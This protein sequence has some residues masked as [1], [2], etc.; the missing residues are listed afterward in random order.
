MTAEAQAAEAQAAV[1]AGAGAIHVHVRGP[2][3]RESLAALDVAHTLRVIRAA[4]PG[5]PVGIS[6]A[7]WIV[8][9]AAERLALVEAWQTL[10]DFVSVNFDEQGAAALAE[11]LLARGVGV[12]AGLA[13][14]QAAAVFVTS[15][16]RDRCLRILL[17]PLEQQVE[18][19]QRTVADMEARLEQAGVR[20]PRLL[21]GTDATAWHF[22]L[23][24][25]TKGQDTRVGLEDMLVLPD[26]R[27]AP[28][29]AALVAAARQ[30]GVVG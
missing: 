3:G 12:E 15:P 29:N 4:C 27:P 22:V 30:V 14:A 17:E 26:G 5:V 6:T 1:A 18:A 13:D 11:Q 23:E 2:D 16:V 28:S 20:L 24:A 7:A 25:A 9:S 21:H 8:E 19:A 10:P